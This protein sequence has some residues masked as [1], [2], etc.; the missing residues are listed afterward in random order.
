MTKLYRSPP[1]LIPIKYKPKA[2]VNTLMM[3]LGW[4]GS[5]I[6]YFPQCGHT[7][8]ISLCFIPLP[9]SL[10]SVVWWGQVAEPNFGELLEPRLL[11]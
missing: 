3:D 10:I 4:Q 9:I 5:F 1:T 6:S 8:Y 11:P 7:E 2:H